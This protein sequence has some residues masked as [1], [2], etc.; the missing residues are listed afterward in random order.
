LAEKINFHD[1][2][3]ADKMRRVLL[4]TARSRMCDCDPS[5]GE[6]RRPPQFADGVVGAAVVAAGRTDD[7]LAFART[8]TLGD[9]EL[10]DDAVLAGGAPDPRARVH[11]ARTLA[12]VDDAQSLKKKRMTF[13][14]YFNVRKIAIKELVTDLRTVAM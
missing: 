12:P 6:T 8:L 13:I 7:R 14:L 9:A 2:T 5:P 1:E 3:E 10:V 4:L 11:P